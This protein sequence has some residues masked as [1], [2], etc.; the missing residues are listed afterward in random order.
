MPRGLQRLAA[1][2]RASSARWRSAEL[3]LWWRTGEYLMNIVNPGRAQNVLTNTQRKAAL[4]K[5]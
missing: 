5:G 1:P 3:A 4:I 2:R